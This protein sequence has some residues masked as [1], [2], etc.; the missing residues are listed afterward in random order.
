M[1]FNLMEVAGQ[2]VLDGCPC[3]FLF[4]CIDKDMIVGFY[5]LVLENFIGFRCILISLLLL[6]C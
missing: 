1:V 2:I 5:S 6:F 3:Q 4:F